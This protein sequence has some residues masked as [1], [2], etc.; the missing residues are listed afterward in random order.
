M[1][2]AVETG[3]LFAFLPGILRV[4][5]QI[6]D[7]A[8]SQD[9]LGI[10]YYGGNLARISLFPPSATVPPPGAPFSDIGWVIY[11]KGLYDIMHQVHRRYPGKPILITENGLADH[12]D[13][14]RPAFIAD[15][16]R[17]LHQAIREGVP[18]E[19]YYHWSLLDNFEWSDGFGPCFGLCAVDYRTGKRTPRPSAWLYAG[20]AA[21]NGLY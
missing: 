1:V 16:L 12:R 17:W 9:F 21:R 8:G 11:P 14:L 15:H 2:D 3:R 20:I 5:E 18:V 4:N 13:A 19:G 6:P 10:N 7:L